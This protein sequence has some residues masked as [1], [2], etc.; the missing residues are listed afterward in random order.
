MCLHSL[1]K[2]NGRIILII[3]MNVLTFAPQTSWTKYNIKYDTA[4]C[5]SGIILIL[6]KTLLTNQPTNQLTKSMVPNPSREAASRS[7][8]QEFPNILWTPQVQYRVHKSPPLAPTLS[9]IQSIPPHFIPLR[10]IFIL[11]FHLRLGL[12]SGLFPS[13]YPTKFLYPFLF[14]PTCTMCFARLIL[15]DFIILITFG[16][17]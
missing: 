11:P 1:H 10:V 5:L 6:K 17:E 8:T 3:G 7:A 12:P 15:L 13:G 4:V 16:E 14:P 2:I 9:Q